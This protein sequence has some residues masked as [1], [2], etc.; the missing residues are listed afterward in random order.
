[1]EFEQQHELSA[2]QNRARFLENQRNEQLQK[3]A[4]K[5]AHEYIANEQRAYKIT[6]Q[7]AAE[8]QRAKSRFEKN[9]TKNLATILE[10]IISDQGKSEDGPDGGWFGPDASAVSASEYDDFC[11]KI[12]TFVVFRKP[13][14]GPSELLGLAID[15]TFSTGAND[16]GNKLNA[17]INF[18]QD[19]PEKSTPKYPPVPIKPNTFMPRVVIALEKTT[20]VDLANRWA[21][22]G[23]DDSPASQANANSLRKHH[24]HLQILDDIILQCQYFSEIAKFENKPNIQAAYDEMAQRIWQILSPRMIARGITDNTIRDTDGGHLELVNALKH[25]D[26]RVRPA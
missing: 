25:L 5:K 8:I 15:V 7:D 21:L 16:V 13:E 14:A 4:A 3:L 22:K 17:I 23:R 20:V 18:I 10:A 11:R 1:M 24:I 19:P 12:D 6:P 26:S 9:D 2:A